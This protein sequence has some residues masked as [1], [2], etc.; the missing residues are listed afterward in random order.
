MPTSPIPK[1]D[2]AREAIDSLRGYVYQIYQSALA[3]I[4]LE[5]EEFLFLEV[6]EDYAVVATDALNAVQ[7][8]DTGH[9][10]TINTEDIIASIDSFVD[11]RQ[12]N[13]ELQVRLRHL[14]TSKIGKEKSK[15]DRIGNT[16]TLEA[17]RTL[18]KAGDL[19][20]LRKI[21]NSSKLSEQ[22]KK[23]IGELDDTEFREGFLKRIH[24]DCGALNSEFLIR[25]LRS[26]LS[27]LVIARG[28]V[29]SQVDGCLNSILMTLLGKAS[30]K[31]ETARFVD[32]NELE[33][34]LEQATHIPVN[35]DQFETQ[36]QLINRLLA[37]SVP[38]THST[39]LVTTRLSE[40][41]PID[42]VPLPAARARRELLTDNILSSLT[43]YGVCWI[44]GTAGV[45]KTTAARIAARRLGGSW[46]GIN[47]R[48]LDAEQSKAVLSGAI[49]HLG[50]QKINGLLVDDLEC[51]HEPY[52]VDSLLYL[53]AICNRADLLLLFTSPKPPNSDFLFSANL[54]AAIGQKTEDFS[55]QDI[56]EILEGLGVQ[57]NNW[58][59]YIYLISGGGHPQLA[60]A[61]IQSM[62][63]SGWDA[64]EFKTLD[65]LLVGNP[66]IEQVRARTRERLLQELPEGG[67]RLLERLSLKIGGFRRSFVLDMAQITPAVSDGGIIF[68]RL[69]GSWVDQQERDQFALSQLLSNLGTKTLTDEQKKKINFEIANSLIKGETLNPI[70]ADSALLAAWSSKNTQAIIWLS[71]AVL[72]TS[73][74]DLKMIAPHLKVF[75]LMRTDTFAYKDDPAVNQMFRGAQLVL[76]CQ[77]E[78]TQ[79]K[80]MEILACFEAESNHVEHEAMR[81]LM[82]FGVY[83][84]L[85][86]SEPKFG[87]L[88]FFWKLI[89]EL[90]LLCEKL[91]KHMP[92]E[93]SDMFIDKERNGM[94]FWGFLF[95]NQTRQIRQI[96]ELLPVFEFLDS[97]DPPFR[98]K[99]LKPY[100]KPEITTDML[101]YKPCL[102]EHEAGTIN[103]PDHSVVFTRL[104]E[105]SNSWTNTELA[106]S[107]RKHRAIIADEY[108]KDKDQAL[109]I[110]DEGMKLYGET[111]SELVRAKAKV[112]YRAD[113][114]Q[115]SLELSKVLIEGNAPL[116]E[117]EKAFLG[118]EA[119]ISAEKQGDF[120]TARRYYLYGSNASRV[121][122]RCSLSE[123]A[124]R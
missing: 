3:W 101:F 112:L 68:D 99:L 50:E 43:Q 113:D 17:W 103:P 106:V 96:N 18:A 85:L 9:N 123:L 117:T 22:T 31:T 104:E 60:V 8:K 36:N 105:F 58:A 82:I 98:Q 38:Q 41:T 39:N 72:R 107:C 77:Q 66:A 63:N 19:A 14:T 57:N 115:A 21:L 35:R 69:I 52:F 12:K 44:F 65:S 75:T 5:P 62:Q 114:H 124:G 47:L 90:H 119:A 74:D 71:L 42:E 46:A 6:A 110:L 118:R 34:L 59:H 25:Q 88:P 108:A 79:E 28:G 111:N 76:V 97:C 15:E 23:Y 26:K 11:L 55:E 67:R 91:K 33:K 86:S 78:E 87:S 16:P 61:A 13:P 80:V 27:Q 54:P 100:S 49:D 4:E 73:R 48:N 102:K 64:N 30:Q 10:V 120:E 70:D 1:G 29:N 122:G 24:F 56:Q 94:A 20:P 84:A 7:V 53:Q 37:A 45:G 95:M 92:Q 81:D 116:N 93:L 51:P 32:R 83:G 121:A 2:K 109:A 89:H 40:P